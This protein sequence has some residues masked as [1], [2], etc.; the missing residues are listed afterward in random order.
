MNNIGFGVDIGGSGIKGAL[1]DL[2]Q[3]EFIGI[4]E[5]IPTPSPSTPAAVQQ[6]FAELLERFDYSG[7]IGCTFPGVVRAQSTIETAA[8]LDD[9][10]I[11]VDAA[12]LF[13]SAGHGA[14]SML[15]DADAAALAE[16][17]WGAAKGV[18]GVVMV[19]TL[20]TGIGSGL[21]HNGVVVPNTELGHLELDGVAAETRASS[22]ARD[23]AE[24][25]F[26]DWGQ[27]LNRYLQH[28]EFL[29]SPDLF[30]LGG[31]ISKHFDKYAAELTVS[32]PVV[33]AALRNRAGIVGAALF[34]SGAAAN[35]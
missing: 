4:R 27:R 5:R 24:L 14:I 18:D 1:V 16:V 30:V 20:G 35:I 3:G 28:V 8:N 12:A 23:D 9:S 11:G 17:K 19:L 26:V 34:G 22:R 31:G 25:S 7:P 21:V 32:A 15:N 2:D 6:V 13:A 29:F 33:P 10:W